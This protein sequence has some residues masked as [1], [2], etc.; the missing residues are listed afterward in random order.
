[1][2]STQGLAGQ[3]GVICTPAAAPLVVS[4]F[5]SAAYYTLYLR[6]L[7]S[8]DHAVP[9]RCSH[10]HVLMHHCMPCRARAAWRVAGATPARGG[11]QAMGGPGGVPAQQ[12]KRRAGGSG[13]GGGQERAGFRDPAGAP[14]GGV[15]RGYGGGA[16]RGEPRRCGRRAGGGGDR[17]VQPRGVPA[18]ACRLA[19]GCARARPGQQAR[20]QGRVGQVLA[21][22]SASQV[23]GA[24]AR[25][26]DRKLG[27]VTNAQTCRHRGACFLQAC[28][29]HMAWQGTKRPP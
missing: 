23:A 24:C 19:A 22:H 1:M 28:Q 7:K 29:S 26:T 5:Q 18:A 12:A 15:P 13:R 8:A 14:Q 25:S 6:G 10:Q 3:V 17:D 4:A 21:T 27:T 16:L 9:M 20:P 11:A 2:L